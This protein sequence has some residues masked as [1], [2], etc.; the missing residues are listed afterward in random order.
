VLVSVCLKCFI[1]SL[2]YVCGCVRTRALVFMCVFVCVCGGGM[3]CPESKAR[4]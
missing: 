4:P 1:H 3:P 2:V